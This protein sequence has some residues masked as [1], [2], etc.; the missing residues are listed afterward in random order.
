MAG[1]YENIGRYVYVN[2]GFTHAYPEGLEL[3]L[4]SLHEEKKRDKVA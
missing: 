4:K 3:C 1:L 2:R